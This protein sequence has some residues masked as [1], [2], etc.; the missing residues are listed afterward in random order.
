MK[1]AKSSAVGVDQF[2]LL[3]LEDDDE[4]EEEGV[5]DLERGCE[6][7]EANRKS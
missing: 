7:E 2:D 1:V 4:D 3:A 6:E 5:E